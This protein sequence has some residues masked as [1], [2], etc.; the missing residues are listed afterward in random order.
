MLSFKSPQITTAAGSKR[1]TRLVRV[2]DAST[3]E[4]AV[5]HD[6]VRSIND[7]LLLRRFP[8]VFGFFHTQAVCDEACMLE[9][10]ASR[11]RRQLRRVRLQEDSRML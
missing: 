1:F 7:V 2:H 6:T 11:L 9:L 10:K 8:Q 4:P 3:S 5:V